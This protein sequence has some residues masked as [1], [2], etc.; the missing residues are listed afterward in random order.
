MK[1]INKII[2]LT[3]LFSGVL[4]IKSYAQQESQF[5][6]YM[7][8]TATINPAY[9]GS[10]GTLD[11][12]SLY[13]NQWA[14][15]NGA[16]KTLNLTGGS[17]IGENLGLGLS[18]VQD[19]IGPSEES[20]IAVDFSY[21]LNLQNDLKFSF[22]LK[23]GINLLNIDYSVLNIDP[24]EVFQFNVDNRLTPIIGVGA[25][26]FKENWY[27]GLSVPNLL[28][29]THYDDSAI[30]NATEKAHFYA[31]GG[32]VFDLNKN[33]KLKPAVMAKFTSG[34]PVAIDMSANFLL[35]E[36]ITL[37]ASYRVDAAVSGLAGFQIS[38]M[39]TVGYAYDYSTSNLGNYNSG[40]HEI[41]LR[42]ELVRYDR[43]KC[44]SPR[45]F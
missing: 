23:G 42:F 37:G 3:L 10:H 24:D 30:S 31:I 36:K 12:I 6:Q 40:S 26:L 14:G 19:E 1:K 45:F 4:T 32:Y 20:T 39:L 43:C 27:A 33:L 44:V 7:Y 38:D 8:N 34:A 15:L 22:G 2:L 5:T 18:F 17:P 16:P 28:E 11:I 29:T 13:R 35:Y 21:T 9:V 41:F 25:Y